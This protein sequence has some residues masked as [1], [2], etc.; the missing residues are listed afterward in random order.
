MKH[1]NTL[2]NTLSKVRVSNATAPFVVGSVIPNDRNKITRDKTLLHEKTAIFKNKVENLQ[3]IFLKACF[4][5]SLQQQLLS[6]TV[7]TKTPSTRIRL[8]GNKCKSQPRRKAYATLT[9]NL[10]RGGEGRWLVVKKQSTTNW[11]FYLLPGTRSV[12][13][14]KWT[15]VK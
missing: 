1:S 5:R 10:G 8:P 7:T 12:R 11:L 4:A 6:I 3:V 2:W 9:L 14:V 13:P 15:K